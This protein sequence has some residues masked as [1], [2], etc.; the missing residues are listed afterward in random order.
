M[1]WSSPVNRNIEQ[2]TVFSIMLDTES[3]I[4][5]LII[6]TMLNKGMEKQREIE[7]FK[8]KNEYHPHFIRELTKIFALYDSYWISR[9][10]TQMT[11][12][13]CTLANMYKVSLTWSIFLQ[14]S[15]FSLTPECTFIYIM[16][17]MCVRMDLIGLLEHSRLKCSYLVE[18]FTF[19]FLH[20]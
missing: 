2:Y 16:K 18:I 8:S 20:P 14:I 15:I 11:L 7:I 1:L 5:M 12:T 9:I 4:R 3:M 6:Q 19:P 10:W 13:P 17:Y